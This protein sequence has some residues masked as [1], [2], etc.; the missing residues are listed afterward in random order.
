MK[1]THS[2]KCRC[3]CHPSIASVGGNGASS[4]GKHSYASSG[5][6][7]W[8]VI[9]ILVLIMVE[10]RTTWS[11]VW[12]L[13]HN[14]YYNDDCN[15]KDFNN[16]AHIIQLINTATLQPDPGLRQARQSCSS[17]DSASKHHS[18]DKLY[19]Y[20]QYYWGLYDGFPNHL[21]NRYLCVVGRWA[22]ESYYV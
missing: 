2:V 20:Q 6:P 15:H 17:L 22:K 11:L 3:I 13:I 5:R 4:C 19:Y 16:T 1:L 10:S 21:Y 18:I 9:D 14:I 7:S 8:A 12:S